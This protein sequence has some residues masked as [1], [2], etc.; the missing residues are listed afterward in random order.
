MLVSQTL[1]R[2]CQ[3]KCEYHIIVKIK[4]GSEQIE[5][6]T[7]TCA[8]NE[9]TFVIFPP[10]HSCG[11]SQK[12]AMNLTVRRTTPRHVA[13]L[14]HSFWGRTVKMEDCARRKCSQEKSRP[15]IAVVVAARKI[16]RMPARAR[17]HTRNGLRWKAKT[18]AQGWYGGKK[19]GAVLGIFHTDMHAAHQF[20]VKPIN[21]PR[22]A[23]PKTQLSTADERDS[24]AH[25][26]RLFSCLMTKNRRDV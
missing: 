26:T 4:F 5:I 10:V 7:S 11:A 24:D 14:R 3:I 19:V 18:S 22:G 13:L 21:P 15:A 20:S 12:K 2:E 8:K 23:S 17:V 6:F 25:D 9:I 1:N 16:K